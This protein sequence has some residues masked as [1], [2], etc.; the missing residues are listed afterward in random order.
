MSDLFDEQLRALGDRSLHRKLR[1]IGN[2][3]GAEIHLTGRR[4]INFSSNDYLGLA[5]DSR[6]REAAIAAIKEYGVDAG[7]SRLISG[8]QSPHVPL[9]EALARC[10]LEG[11]GSTA[12]LQ[13]RLRRSDRH[14]ADAGVQTRCRDSR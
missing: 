13:Q 4:L 11:N 7:A 9:E 3:Q 6:L 14:I 10:T 5:A 1:E 8:T 2:A 12:L